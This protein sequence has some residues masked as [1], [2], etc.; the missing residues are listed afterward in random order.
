[1]SVYCSLAHFNE[2]GILNI[3]T[4]MAWHILPS[5][6]KIKSLFPTPSPQ[7]AI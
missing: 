5:N 6:N 3:Q 4:Y 1:M 7:R 2:Q